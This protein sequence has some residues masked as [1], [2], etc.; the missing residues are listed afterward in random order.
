MITYCG[1]C[2]FAFDADGTT[3]DEYN[4]AMH[5]HRN[6]LCGDFYYEVAEIEKDELV[7]VWASLCE[8]HKNLFVNGKSTFL[9]VK[10]RP[11]GYE[12]CINNATR[13]GYVKVSCNGL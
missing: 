11:C 3:I 7:Y 9:T 5:F 6:S 1:A 8:E 12:L 2:G 4:G 10:F 13:S